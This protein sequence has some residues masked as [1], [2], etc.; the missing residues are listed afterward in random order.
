MLAVLSD[1]HGN[2]QALE[3]VWED[4]EA[5]GADEVL[6]LGD[7]VGYGPQPDEVVAFLRE[8]GVSSCLGNHEQGLADPAE[9]SARFNP[10]ALEALEVT[11]SLLSPES[12][13]WSVDLPRAIVRHGAR[14]VHGAPPDAVNAYLFQELHKGKLA[15]RMRRMEENLCFAG[16]THEL[17][18]YVLEGDEVVKSRLEP[19]WLRIDPGVKT[20]LNVGAVGQ[21]RDGDPRAKYVLWD[22]G[23]R[24]EVRR[25][26]YDVELTARLIP[27]AGLPERYARRLWG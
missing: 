18:R 20:I 15:G 23:E 10:H 25:V 27:E 5:Q 9:A 26:P 7:N 11:R 1:I 19:G 17:R 13:A 3:A 12:L 21:P 6:T 16:H 2:F 24:A 8:R 14:F 4:L 22:R